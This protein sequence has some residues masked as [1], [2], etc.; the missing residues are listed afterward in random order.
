MIIDASCLALFVSYEEGKAGLTL[1][2][3]EEGKCVG[4]QGRAAGGQAV[5]GEETLFG[6]FTS[7]YEQEIRDACAVMQTVFGKALFLDLTK[8]F[9]ECWPLWG[10]KLLPDVKALPVEKVFIVTVSW[11]QVGSCSPEQAGT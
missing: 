4:V 11:T 2:P 10:A 9:E 8:L 1:G 6:S 3:G 5:P 7:D